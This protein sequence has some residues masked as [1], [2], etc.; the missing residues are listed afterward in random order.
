MSP[1]T[2]RM[3]ESRH[4]FPVPRRLR[5]GHRR[6]DDA[7]VAAVLEVR[8]RRDAGIALARAIADVRSAPDQ[9][10]SSVFAE[11]RRRF[12]RQPT[13]RLRK[14]T[15]LALSRAFEDECCAR[16]DRATVVGA[17]QSARHFRSSRD[18]WREL[19]RVARV[20]VVL[21]ADFDDS[22]AAAD[23]LVRVAVPPDSP[24]RR[25]W[26]VVLDAPTAPMLLTG[27][28]VPGQ[29]HVPDRDRVFEAMWSLEPRVVQAA[30]HAC[31]AVVAAEEPAARHLLGPESGPTSDTGRFA[32]DPDG[33]ARLAQR[34]LGHVDDLSR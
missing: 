28:E 14:T 34:V 22:G 6:Y 27:W 5:S 26:L 11:V 8:G 4:G 18:R 2:L 10:A 12:P 25:E 16:A 24:M 23:D 9:P 1:A 33:A 19:A 17:F 30:V 7:T 13:Q 15:M 29:T 21:A 32:V 31:A 3:W 20:T